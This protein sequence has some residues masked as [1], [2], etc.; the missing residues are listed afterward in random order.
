MLSLD[1]VTDFTAEIKK[2]WALIPWTV[3]SLL[4]AFLQW[5]IYL[6]RL[7]HLFQRATFCFSKMEL[8]HPRTESP[9]QCSLVGRE[10]RGKWFGA[11]ILLREERWQTQLKSITEPKSYFK[12]CLSSACK[13]YDYAWQSH[14]QRLWNCQRAWNLDCLC[15][16]IIV[17]IFLGEIFINSYILRSTPT[18]ININTVL[19]WNQSCSNPDIIPCI[20]SEA[21]E[22]L[23]LPRIEVKKPGSLGLSQSQPLTFSLRPRARKWF[24]ALPVSCGGGVVP[25]VGRPLRGPCCETSL[26]YWT[27]TDCELSGRKGPRKIPGI[28][29][30]GVQELQS[31]P[32]ALSSKS[33]CSAVLVEPELTSLRKSYCWL[34]C[35]RN[36]NISPKHQRTIG[37]VMTSFNIGAY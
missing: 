17:L 12:H 23:D 10:A 18:I 7:G 30:P 35:E 31:I 34:S 29:I 21:D 25:P 11:Y 28:C 24:N 19:Q 37:R 13:N 32:Q 20:G 1:L 22:W 5:N 15:K 2:R 26:Q 6:F 14:R 8:G 3:H 9:S 27:W 16:F 36:R 4:I 33:V